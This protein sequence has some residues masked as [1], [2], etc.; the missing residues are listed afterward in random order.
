MQADQLGVAD[1][2]PPRDG[3]GD[4]A[5]GVGARCGGS[6][7]AADRY[8]LDLD[9]CCQQADQRV[10]RLAGVALI[11]VQLQRAQRSERFALVSS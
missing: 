10:R 4:E 6:D 5:E 1:C 3:F 7:V 2:V 8:R 11:E 9:G